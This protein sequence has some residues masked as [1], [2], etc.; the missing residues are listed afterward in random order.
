MF[1]KLLQFEW[2]YH[3][4]SLLFYASFLVYLCFGISVG[5]FINGGFPGI[6]KNSPFMI[7]YFI[8]LFS[9]N[10]VFSTTLFVAQSFLRESETKFDSIVY[11]TPVSKWNYLGSRFLMLFFVSAFSFV[12]FALGIMIGHLMLQKDEM[13]PF[14]FF[15][16]VIPIVTFAL[17]NIFFCTSVLAGLAWL[18]RSKLIIYVGGLF[19][20][21][22]YTIGSIFSNSPVFA[23]A[24]PAST[25][26]MSV[27]AK[28]D[29]FGMAAFFEQS[30]YWTAF[31]RNTNNIMLI[32]NFL[33]NRVLFFLISIG[34]LFFS[35]RMF[36]F[37]KM[38][39]KKLKKEKTLESMPII[40]KFTQLQKIEFQTLKHN[41]EVLKSFTKIDCTLIIKGI[42]FLLIV[43]LLG[44]L[45]TI[46]IKD[47]INGGIRMAESITNTALMVSTIMDRLSFVMILV[48]LFYSNE[49]LWRS[50]STRFEMLENVTPY[51]QSIVFIS[52]LISLVIVPFLLLIMSI[53]IGVSFQII[54]GNAP[55]E[56]GLYLSLF[57]FMGLPIAFVAV[58]ILSIQTLIRNRYVGLVLA[59]VITLL[60]S[61]SVGKMVGINYPLF[62]FAETLSREYFDMNGF[63]KYAFSFHVKMLYSFG[64]TLILLFLSGNFPKNNKISLKTIIKFPKVS[65]VQKGI[66][67]FGGLFFMS[68]GSYIFYETNV[69]CP[70][71]IKEDQQN[72]SQQYEVKYRKFENFSQPA[73]T[74]LKT[75][76]DL[77]PETNSY[78]VKGTYILVNN[79]KEAIDSLLLYIDGNTTLTSV[80]IPNSKMIQDDSD[81]GH[82]WY[83]LNK[84]LQP[85]E[86][87][88][89]DFS[90]T[91]FWSPFKGHTSFNSIIDNGSFMRISRYYPKFGYQSDNELDDKNERTKRKMKPITPLKKLED[92]TVVPYN[93]IDFEAIVSTSGDQIAVGSGNLVKQ[94]KSNNRNYF[95]YKADRK[96]PFRFA[97]SSAKYEVKREIYKGIPIEIYYD[98]RHDRN[99]DEIIRSTKSSLDYC[100]ENFGKY[101]HKIIRYAEISAF[102]S[103]FAAT[104]YPGTIY[105]KENMGFNS[106]ISRGDKE[107]IINQL[108]GHELSHQWWGNDKLSPEVREGGVILTET[109]A[110]YTELMLYE[111]RHGR[112][113]ALETIKVHLDLYLSSRSFDLEMP[114]YKITYDTPHLQYDKGMIIMHQ[115]RWLIGETNL[116]K[117]L[118]N[119]SEHYS[120]P[121]KPA[122]TRDLIAEIYKISP[123]E[124]H[125]KID[126]M[127]KQIITYSSK[128]ESVSSRKIS[129]KKYEVT[130]DIS[131]FK[132]SE[133]EKGNRKL[134]PNDATIDI[135]IYDENGKLSI[136]TF[137]LKNNR[138][139]GKMTVSGNPNRIVVDPNLKNIDTFLEDNEKDVN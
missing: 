137:Q 130:F 117:A 101:P 64:I 50:E 21:I 78:Q 105:M 106:D 71:V 30:R 17:P 118:K 49:L 136:Q 133:G 97:F 33:F 129:N 63:G 9:M 131:S 5:G 18:T 62:R 34:I 42:P 123:I 4:R 113:R 84:R 99:V 72:W 108:A 92:S 15:N 138:V 67:I 122:D 59:T 38:K 88:T 61:T 112:E 32:D 89:I 29:P 85:N 124:L 73:I 107:D 48:M 79:S 116:N 51:N 16:Y 69:R 28:L 125:P 128:I 100:Q 54:K 77:F 90:F 40:S 82:Y 47:E 43:I 80:S 139:K 60:L 95:H 134:I 36:S 120:F 121:D 68:F 81:F 45:L 104:A 25:A 76:V 87:L 135:G 46:E 41:I 52:K 70:Y 11:A 24:S 19:I 114:L 37:R 2:H 98:K 57:Y 14:S 31:E 103:G 132:F 13:A 93:F 3:T 96:M 7:T 53:L 39:I 86:Q 109:L 12:M 44:G 115:L 22:L 65:F 66:L 8:G 119:L 1:R 23:G 55:I 26:S 58:L 91:S 56:W 110:Q 94:W 27:V 74:S 75:D 10:T 6:Y 35:Y 111:K 83:K 127:F 102:V 20:F 126:E